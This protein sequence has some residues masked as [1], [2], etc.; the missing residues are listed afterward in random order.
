MKR[1]LLFV[2]ISAVA[3]GIYKWEE[4]VPSAAAGNWPHVQATAAILMDADSGEILMSQNAEE[5]LPPASMSKMMTELVVLNQVKAGKLNWDDI[6][7]T[8]KYAAVVIGAQIGFKSGEQLTVRELFEAMIVHSANDAAVA[9]A[10]FTAGSE[11]KFVEL[12]NRQAKEIGL[13]S[14]AHFANATGLDRE[15]LIGLS[16]A[17]SKGNTYLS[18]KDTAELARHLITAY[19][20]VLE[21]TTRNDIFLTNQVELRTTNLMLPG[22]RFAYSG[23]DGLKTG[24]TSQAGYCFTG[25]TKRGST[26]LIAVVMGADS[27][28][29]RFTETKKLF[30]YGFKKERARA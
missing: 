10:E 18:A 11:A 16:G 1:I 7:V 30:H 14:S 19:P 2:I 5:A 13:S 8:S 29:T 25:T 12:M 20:E 26:R 3:V 23:N 15:D 22:E 28:D 17:A 9:L 24:Y 6:V 4:S 27:G 21:I